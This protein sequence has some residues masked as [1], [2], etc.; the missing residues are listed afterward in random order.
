[1]LTRLWLWLLAYFHLSD[2]AVCEMSRGM[3]VADY[4][5]YPDD[6]R[7]IPVHFAT[8]R[9]KRCGKTFHL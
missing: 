3:G 8:L 1:M 6:E 9:C 2:A 4:H 7:G 5:D